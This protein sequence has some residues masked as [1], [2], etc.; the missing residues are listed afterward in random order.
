L[1]AKE[2]VKIDLNNDGRPDIVQVM[3]D[4]REIC[5]A[6]DFNFDGKIDTFLYFDAQGNLRR[7][8]SDFDRDGLI[9]EIA[10]YKNGV[11]VEKHR[12]TNLDGKLDT[13]DTYV[14]G[15]LTSR[16][17]DTNRDGKVDQWW[18][19]P[20]P[21]R[22]DCPVIALDETGEGKP[23]ARHEPCGGRDAASGAPGSSNAQ[24]PS[25]PG[26]SQRAPADSG[27]GS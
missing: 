25:Q 16:R 6:I 20:D 1:G 17:L 12:E 14:N 3:K 19:F 11:V 21:S 18:K 23:T 24:R 15:Q 4:G 9:D 13:W 27:G 5:R 22:Q 10:F 2:A 7:R 8:E 26:T